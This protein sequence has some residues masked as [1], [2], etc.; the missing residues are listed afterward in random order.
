[1]HVK[2]T[3]IGTITDSD[4]YYEI[5]VPG[6]DAVLVF[7][8]IG[9]KTR[10]MEVGSRTELSLSLSEDVQSL[11]EIVVVGYGVQKKSDL[12]G[13][14]TQVKSEELNE[15]AVMGIDQALQGRAAGVQVTN[16]SGMPGAGVMVTIR[17][18]GTWNDSDPLY[19]IDGM[20]VENDISFLNPSD[21]ETIEILKDASA[22]AIYGARAANGVVLITTKRGAENTS[23]VNFDFYTGIQNLWKEVEV[24][25]APGY[26]SVYNDLRI[27]AGRDPD[28]PRESQ[29][30]IPD[31][32]TKTSTNWQKEVF[33]PARISDYNLSFTGGTQKVK[34]G[35]TGSYFMQEGIMKKSDFNR[36]TFRANTDIKITDKLTFGE[37]FS[38]GFSEAHEVPRGGGN[39]P[40]LLALLGDPIA[41]VYRDQDDPLYDYETARWTELEWSLNPNPVGVVERLD[42]ERLKTPIILNSY[43]DYEII[44]GLSVKINGGLNLLF[45][46]YED[47]SQTYYEGGFSQNDLTTMNQRTWKNLSWLFESTI[48]YNRVFAEKHDI[49]MLAG[50]SRQY[51]TTEDFLA[52]K[53]D[54]P[55]NDDEYRFLVFGTDIIQPS[56]ILATK[57]EAAI[58]S[59]FGRINYSLNNKYLFTGII[60]RDGS[61]RF[62]PESTPLY[63]NTPRYDF[64]PSVSLGWKLSEEPFIKNNIDAI[65]FMKLRLGWG[66]LG[67][68]RTNRGNDYPWFSAVETNETLQNYVFGGQVSTGSAIVGKA[69]RDIR[70]E[71][72]SQTNLGLDV[73]FFN[74]KLSFT[75]DVYKK[76]TIDQLVPVPL[77]LIVGV[78]TNPVD[79]KLGGNP[80][81]NAGEVVNKGFEIIADYRKKEGKFHYE[82]SMNFT[83]NINEV[84]K[85]GKD[86]EAIESGGFKG[87]NISVT[88]PGYAIASFWGYETDGL[89]QE[90][91]DTDGDGLVDNQ[92]FI[93]GENDEIIYMQPNAKPGDIK[94]KDLNGDNILD[95]NDKTLI[96]SPHP[97]FSYGINLRMSYTG[98]DFSMFWQGVW[99]NQIFATLVNDFLGGNP[100]TNFHVNALNA[101]HSPSQDGSDPGLVNTDIPRLDANQENQNFRVSDF[102]IMDGAYLRLKNAQVG[103][104]IPK[105]LLSFAGV[106]RLRIYL[107]AQNLLTFTK[108]EYGYD[109]EIGRTYNNYGLRQ[110]KD[111]QQT[112][113]M[114]IDRGV[115]PQA[116]TLMFGLNLIF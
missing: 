32:L 10:E 112:L 78:F 49:T 48:N 28:N 83:R 114:A 18:M 34:Y 86:V 33:R 51:S 45:H 109:P 94:F 13:A 1:M 113:Q 9:Y 97:D 96:G 6:D 91:D 61:S 56:D 44:K 19:V 85:L 40:H 68:D 69:V 80:L 24:T 29:Y 74:N 102:Y 77:P 89:F 8:F 92:P 70:W 57:T 101:Y 25:D 16:N 64:F 21:I 115:Y 47:F 15:S 42:N 87:A 35:I 31:S 43:L 52:K 27:S 3:T 67:N 41:S 39:S 107:A 75:A 71:R 95:G 84:V 30:F 82:V 62:G 72:S 2:G 46:E 59:F 76:T 105:K 37:R 50:F 66:Q 63:G 110:E 12:T 14:I 108:Y 99:G 73:N 65:S 53:I 111:N 60:R 58:E 7:T 88:Q 22:G 36:F 23:T 38:I 100:N 11:D 116:R 106:E 20:P 55:G 81:L 4:G 54:F 103:Y 90:S 79:T 5:N 26:R 93:T 17:G 98:F 104:T